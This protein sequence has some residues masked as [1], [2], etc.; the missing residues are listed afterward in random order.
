MNDNL[1]KY[2]TTVDI[3]IDRITFLCSLSAVDDHPKQKEIKAELNEF[4]ELIMLLNEGYTAAFKE[5][6]QS[7]LIDLEHGA[8]KQLSS[9]ESE[10]N[11]KFSHIYDSIAQEIKEFQHA[12][13]ES[14]LE[15]GISKINTQQDAT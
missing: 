8:D 2:P 12:L 7:K 10:K 3:L 1:K 13:K 14:R 15:L 9:V 5:R 11:S 4:V 6:Y